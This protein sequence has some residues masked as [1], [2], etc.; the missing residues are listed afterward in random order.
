M[1][2]NGVYAMDITQDELKTLLDYSQ[3]TGVFRWKVK[4]N[5]KLKIGDVAGRFTNHGYIQIKIGGK[6][7]LAHRL[8][9]MYVNGI[10]P[11]EGFQVDH[12]D[13]K[14]SNNAFS[15]LRIV[16]AAQNQQNLRNAMAT[17]RSCGVLGVSF[18]K[19]TK[20]FV[21]TIGVSGTGIR[22]GSFPTVDE[23]IVA[24]NAGVKKYFTHSPLNT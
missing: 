1:D 23:A 18:N 5:K 6:A 20:R 22:L 9:F 4:S 21:A 16:T 13:G 17:N 11:Q 19:R 7:F 3:A 24:R 10:F 8:A 14:R 15:N 12:I 2:K